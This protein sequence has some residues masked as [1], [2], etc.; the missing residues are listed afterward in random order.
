MLAVNNAREELPDDMYDRVTELSEE[1]NDF[2][3]RGDTKPAISRW[4]ATLQLQYM[5]H[6]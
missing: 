5:R 6:I 4:G 3:D 2:L 1:G